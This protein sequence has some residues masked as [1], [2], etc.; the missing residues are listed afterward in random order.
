LDRMVD[1][2]LWN[3][4]HLWTRTDGFGNDDLTCGGTPSSWGNWGKNL[5]LTQPK[6]IHDSFADQEAIGSGADCR[7]R[8]GLVTSGGKD[9]CHPGQEDPH[10]PTKVKDRLQRI[11][12]MSKRVLSGKTC[13]W[14]ISAGRNQAPC[15]SLGRGYRLQLLATAL[16]PVA[17]ASLSPDSQCTS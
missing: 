6:E 10:R 3:P 12:R 14:K 1:H 5:P 2:S 9:Q 13:R 16:R 4:V 7:F 11:L 17:T 8:S 15:L